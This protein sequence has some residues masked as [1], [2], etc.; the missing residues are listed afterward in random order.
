MFNEAKC[1]GS[2]LASFEAAMRDI[3]IDDN[4]KIIDYID[5]TLTDHMEGAPNSKSDKLCTI[6]WHVDDL[7]LLLALN[8]LADLEIYL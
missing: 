8:R 6:V 5:F 4:W 2:G 7:T 1:P 3:V